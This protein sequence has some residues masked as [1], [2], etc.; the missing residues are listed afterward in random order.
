[1]PMPSDPTYAL[2]F[3]SGTV[4]VSTRS[5]GLFGG[6]NFN[7]ILN[8]LA[9]FKAAQ[10]A[11]R[12][13]YQKYGEDLGAKLTREQLAQQLQEFTA[14]QNEQKFQT[15]LPF[16]QQ[17][18]ARRLQSPD[19]IGLTN[20]MNQGTSFGPNPFGTSSTPIPVQIS[21]R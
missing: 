10:D 18:M 6:M 21:G 2:T 19:Q 8:V 16:I 3:P 7:D 11:R 9:P 4:P 13:S 14:Q 12:F 5:T 15:A 1:M 17:W 20:F